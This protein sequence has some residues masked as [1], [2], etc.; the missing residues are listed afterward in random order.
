M[1]T[2]KVEKLDVSTV[3]I[4]DALYTLWEAQH[5]TIYRED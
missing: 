4:W 1:D 2:E 5:I 3:R